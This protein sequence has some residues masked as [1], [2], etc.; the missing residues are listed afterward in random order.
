MSTSVRPALASDAPSLAFIR[1]ATAESEAMVDEA[2]KRSRVRSESYAE[3]I[4]KHAGLAYVVETGG[5]VVGFVVLQH[6]THHAV[7][8][9]NPL[10]LWQL[11]V[12][13]ALH[14]SGVAS[15]L[16]SAVM[17]H[18]R[19]HRHDVIWLGV[20]EHNARGLAFYRKHDFKALGV[21]P[22]GTGGHGHQDVV[23]SC[24]VQ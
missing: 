16:M 15:Q 14:G 11:F 5:S 24:A 23:M 21:H 1:A 12:A 3:L 4:Q 9:R 18:A 19:R 8:G 2:T 10:K 22:V 17:D 20:S 7:V 13:P 6:E